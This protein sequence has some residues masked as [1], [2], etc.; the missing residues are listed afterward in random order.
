MT[1]AD[2]LK[3]LEGKIKYQRL[4]EEKKI[5]DR[6]IISLIN[7]M[8]HELG[9]TLRSLLDLERRG[10]VHYISRSEYE[11][12]LKTKRVP[13][14]IN[15]TARKNLNIIAWSVEQLK[16]CMALLGT[17][18]GTQMLPLELYPESKN[19][20]NQE[21]KRYFKVAERRKRKAEAMLKKQEK[22]KD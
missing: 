9:M 7:S 5:K 17:G 3:E 21:V 14:R 12:A 6:K 4:E 19:K 2:Q 8:A 10:L 15:S 16:V 20:H 1:I 18:K 13:S 11:K 22:G